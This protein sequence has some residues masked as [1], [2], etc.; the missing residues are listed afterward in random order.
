[1]VAIFILGIYFYYAHHYFVAPTLTRA[2][3]GEMLTSLHLTTN[4]KP[5]G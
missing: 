5:Q 1:M 4:I 2:C 3:I